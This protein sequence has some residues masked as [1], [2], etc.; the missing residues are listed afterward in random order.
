MP[1][2]VPLP[3]GEKLHGTLPPGLGEW[4][5]K[6]REQVLGPVEPQLLV[7]KLY[8][9]E[10]AADT[11]V[12]QEIGEWKPLSEVWFLGAHVARAR[13]RMAYVEAREQRK[14][15][16]TA[17]F[18]TRLAGALFAFAV[19]FLAA[20]GGARWTIIERPWADKTDWLTHRPAFLDLPARAPRLAAVTPAAQPPAAES[21]RREEAKADKP[22]RRE[23]RKDR[24]DRSGA[25][26]KD[27]DSKNAQKSKDKDKDK[28]KAKDKAAGGDAAKN[29]DVQKSAPAVT[30]VQA[31]LSNNQI[32][33]IFKGGARGYTTCIRAEASRNPEM[34][35]TITVEFIIRNDGST[36]DFKVQ[37]REIRSGPLATCL[38]A[39]IGALR[40]P[41][42][43]GE[44]K[45][46][47]FPFKI[48]RRKGT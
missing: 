25:Q 31:E 3:E 26:A 13:Q 43:T 2:Q 14:T 32:L 7:S 37:E 39:K 47:I 24:K 35:G 16:L 6:D 5:F 8:A 36:A 38:A 1:A 9:G 23:E 21:P 19:V 10:V 44:R 29:T 33:S 45:Q 34:P 40:F 11:P 41:R 28:A 27:R 46:F 18:R 15:V 48:T 17:H 22:D 20:L 30:G 42:F 4:L 12:A